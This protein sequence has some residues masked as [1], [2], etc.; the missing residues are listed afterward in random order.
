[1]VKKITSNPKWNKKTLVLSTKCLNT[2]CHTSV[3]EVKIVNGDGTTIYHSCVNPQSARGNTSQ[4]ILAVLDKCGKPISGTVDDAISPEDVKALSDQVLAASN[5]KIKEFINAEGLTPTGSNPVNIFSIPSRKV[6]IIDT[7]SDNN[8]LT[9][10]FKFN[11]TNSLGNFINPSGGSK[12]Y[13]HTFNAGDTG[14]IKYPLQNINIRQ[15]KLD[16]LV[17]NNSLT[18][19]PNFDGYF[20]PYPVKIGGVEYPGNTVLVPTNEQ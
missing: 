7:S 11:V 10:S 4:K 18:K 9:V 19:L 17:E 5:Q 14:K 1:M 6:Q 20:V 8:S 3:Q 15:G 2:A 16:R 13:R 12:P